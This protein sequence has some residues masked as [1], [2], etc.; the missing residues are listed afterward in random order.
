MANDFY[1]RTTGNLNFYGA[2]GTSGTEPDMRQEFIDT[3]D[4]SYPEIAKAQPGVLRRMRRDEDD[5]LVSCECVDEITQEPDKDR[6]CP[7]CF[8]EGNKWDEEEIEFYRTVESSDTQNIRRD[9]L[10]DAGLLNHPLVVFYIKYDAEIT[11]DDKIIQLIL[12]ADG[13][14]ETP[15]RRQQV[16]R[17]EMVWDFRSDNGKLEYYK[18]FAHTESVKYLNA[19]SYSEV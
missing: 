2:S 5:H 18:I 3:M 7:V 17:I 12:A 1:R 4:G 15:R 11:K 8:G 14:A 19:P 16:F 6:F 13:T 10:T 9:R